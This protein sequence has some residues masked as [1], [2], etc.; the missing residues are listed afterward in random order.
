M[1]S[2]GALILPLL[3]G[4]PGVPNDLPTPT[5]TPG[6]NTLAWQYNGGHQAIAGSYG[7]KHPP[8]EV[9]ALL[10]EPLEAAGRGR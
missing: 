6:G 7:V 10:C 2:L 1:V 9:G 8:P 3:I 5:S 4:C